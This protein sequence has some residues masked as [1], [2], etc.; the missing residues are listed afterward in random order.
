MGKYY[1]H[2]I[3]LSS[4]HQHNSKIRH[5]NKEAWTKRLDVCAGNIVKEDFK[6]HT[7]S[8]QSWTLY[9]SFYL[10][11]KQFLIICAAPGMKK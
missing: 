4:A 7:R 2:M 3:M 1:D 10:N 8:Q 11:L 9:P 6:I 5:W